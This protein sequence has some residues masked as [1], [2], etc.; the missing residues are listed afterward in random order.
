LISNAVGC[1]TERLADG[2][3]RLYTQKTGTHVHCPLPDSVVK[4]LNSIPKM[5]ERFWS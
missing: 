3:L 2:K 4:E 5:S 1:S